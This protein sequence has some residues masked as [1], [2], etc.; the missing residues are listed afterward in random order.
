M[1]AEQSSARDSAGTPGQAPAIAKTC[2]YE[3]LGVDRQASDE[4][5]IFPLVLPL[6]SSANFLPLRIEKAYRR[7]ALELHPDRNYGDVENATKQF[8]EVQ[9][10]YE[11]L[12]DPQERLWYDSHRDAILGNDDLGEK[13]FEHNIRLTRASDII[14]LMSRFTRRIPF[15]DA[16]NGFYGSLRMMF[17]TLAGEED[18]ASEWEGLEA[19]QYP[20]FG[21]MG[22]SY[23]EVVRPFYAA[24]MD[25][26]TR[27]TFSW[28]DMYN[29]AEAPD[30]RIR[31][32]MEKENKRLRDEGIK[33]FNDAV[34]SLV[35][36][37]RKRDPRFIPNTQ[38]EADRQKLLRGAAAAQAARSRAANQAKLDKQSVPEW[39]K[40]QEA[41]VEPLSDSDP[42]D[43]EH[44]EC[45]TCGKIFKSEK[46][47]EAHEKSKKHIKAVQQLKRQ[48][49]KENKL[50]KLGSHA[51]HND[52][53]AP[54]STSNENLSM[55]SLKQ[56]SYQNEALL[57]GQT[58]NDGG[59]R[60]NSI[61]VPQTQT[62]LPQTKVSSTHA[63]ST[64][65]V[66]LEAILKDLS[67]SEDELDEDY[68]SKEEVEARLS[69]L[70]VVDDLYPSCHDQI[71]GDAP[72]EVVNTPRAFSVAS[73]SNG[74]GEQRRKLGKAKAKRAKK[75]A[76]HESSVQGD[77]IV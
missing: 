67:T 17:E 42:S 19:V 73:D 53:A 75:A 34:R 74:D 32:L 66:R 29:Y 51:I 40:G 27:K 43:E 39:M 35:A 50:F 11:V 31:R 30:R 49:E 59:T 54:Q 16:P 44:F 13:H 12:S 20:E 68:A 9:S 36:F 3:V 41:E 1:G 38:S 62:E 57:S 56:W 45:V 25:F 47:Y 52:E 8:A 15:T 58:L 55:P 2:Y 5:C 7:K 61:S 4:E 24:W 22:D 72:E 37:V 71:N 6:C 70:T 76:R 23:A 33:E 48:M 21:G 60:P 77:T 64:R 46:Q 18:A 63:D 14:A 10:A 69:R 26:T 65:P 28:L